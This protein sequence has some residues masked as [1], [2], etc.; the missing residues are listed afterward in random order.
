MKAILVIT[1]VLVACTFAGCAG[2]T[3][4]S[5]SQD[6][7]AVVEDS[8]PTMEDILDAHVSDSMVLCDNYYSLVNQGWTDDEIFTQLNNAGAFD[9]YNGTGDEF[10]HAMIRWCYKNN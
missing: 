10:F 2:T 8:A 5:S 6:S 7:S 9:G 1:L 4:S 3:S